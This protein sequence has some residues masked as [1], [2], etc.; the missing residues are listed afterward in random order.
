MS[1]EIIVRS[2]CSA[3]DG[4]G[5]VP[6]PR[7]GK[8]DCPNRCKGGVIVRKTTFADAAALRGTI[9]AA[10]RDSRNL[11]YDEIGNDADAVLTAEGVTDDQR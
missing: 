1:I 9:I 3:C 11:G 6:N 10:I 4:S 5:L 7:G 2:P 8:L